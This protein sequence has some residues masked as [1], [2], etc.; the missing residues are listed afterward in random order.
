[1]IFTRILETTVLGISGFHADCADCPSWRCHRR[2]HDT[3]DAAI[4]CAKR[5]QT[6]NH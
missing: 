4:R 2:P 5:H 3:I 6:N 1:M